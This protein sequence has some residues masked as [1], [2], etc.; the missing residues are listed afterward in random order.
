MENPQLYRVEQGVPRII[1]FAYTDK[2]AE[3]KMDYRGHCIETFINSA[4][5]K[6]LNNYDRMCIAFDLL[7]QIIWPLSKIH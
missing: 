2:I 5:Y 7:R 1:G 3:L 4:A 6:S